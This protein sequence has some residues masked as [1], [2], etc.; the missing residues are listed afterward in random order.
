ML[1]EAASGLVLRLLRLCG[2]AGFPGAVKAW[3]HAWISHLRGEMSRIGAQKQDIEGI[4]MSVL[5]EEAYRNCQELLRLRCFNRT[6]RASYS[7]RPVNVHGAYFRKPLIPSGLKFL[8]QI[9][10][11]PAGS[12]NQSQACLPAFERI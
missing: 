9:R 10:V 7:N 5:S 1:K 8:F 6:Y 3:P 11:L 4:R 2:M 12:I